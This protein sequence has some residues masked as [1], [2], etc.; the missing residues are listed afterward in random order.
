MNQEHAM[1][2]IL[3][4]S[5]LRGRNG[6]NAPKH[7]DTTDTDTETRAACKEGKVMLQTSFLK[8][9]ALFSVKCTGVTKNYCTYIIF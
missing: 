5:L 9:F 2:T 3:V 1:L 7:A 4:L 8:I 6:A